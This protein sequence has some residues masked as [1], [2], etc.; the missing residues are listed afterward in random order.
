MTRTLYPVNIDIQGW[1]VTVIGAGNVAARK[2]ASL[3]NCGARV[4][5]I[6]PVVCEEIGL[7]F[8]KGLVELEKRAYQTGDLNGCRLVFTLTDQPE[9]QR[10]VIAEAQAHSIPV[11]AADNPEESTFHVPASLKRG[12]LLLCV[13]T[14]G[15]SPLLAAKIREELEGRY[16]K[17]YGLF[18]KLLSVLR[19][20]LH[21]LDYG[22]AELKNVFEKLFSLNILGHIQTDS[23]QIIADLLT[24]ELPEGFDVDGVIE[25]TRSTI[26]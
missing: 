19:D 9:V 10:A 18:I 22:G 13:S 1:P 6:S 4:K 26:E 15:G 14:G 3:L 12:D 25:E 5:I 8:S 2:V 21:S 11:N 16:G 7:Y 17:E 23:W 20:R 24:V